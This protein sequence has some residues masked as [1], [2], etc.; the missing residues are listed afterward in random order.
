MTG[1]HGE[2]PKLEVLYEDNHLIAV[3]KP[4]GVPSQEDDSGAPDMLTLVKADL[5]RRHA[6]PGDV[7]LG[8][9]HRLDRPVGGVMLFAKTSKAAS[10]LSEAVRERE[11]EKCYIAVVTGVPGR[12][13]ATLVHYLRKDART[14][15]VR[16]FG[17][18]QPGAKEAILDYRAVA[19][20]NGLTLLAVRL[21][22]G[23]SHQIRVQL[24]ANGTPLAGD[25]KYGNDARSADRPESPALWS[26]S[27]GVRHPVTRQWLLT[28]ALPPAVQPWT[29][30][31]ASALEEAAAWF[32]GDE[33]PGGQS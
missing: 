26:A 1:S 32:R 29:K 8:L 24:A 14:N 21:H 25:R 27:V 16:A 15:T 19:S 3:I 2:S 12:Q 5:K 6:K 7:Y 30:F 31:G 9:I 20:A 23:R 4:P 13:E 28:A 10:R 33:R 22:T 18:P 17:Q 11:F